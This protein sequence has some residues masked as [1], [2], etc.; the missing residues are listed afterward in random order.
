[1]L[2]HPVA[3]LTVKRFD[4]PRSG[5]GVASSAGTAALVSEP[6]VHS[7]GFLHR[8][9]M[10]GLTTPKACQYSR[11]WEVPGGTPRVSGGSEPP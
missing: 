4:R 9:S 2:E 8:L 6:K 7:I 11:E 1:M 3:E 10:I 5:P